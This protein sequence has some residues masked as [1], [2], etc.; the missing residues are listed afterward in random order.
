MKKAS[1]LYLNAI[2][3]LAVLTINALA[4][5]LPINGYN[6]GQVSA[7]Y[8]SL[9]T[10]A[11]FTFSIWSVIYLLLILFAFSQKRIFERD[12]FSALSKWFLI[13]CT[14]NFCWILAWHYLL[15]EVSVL[16]MLL[17][18]I[19]LIK[20]FTLLHQQEFSMV[21]T[22]TFQLPFTFYFSWICVATIANISAVLV[23]WQWLGGPLSPVYWTI[24]LIIIAALLGIFIAG[25]FR[26]PAFLLVTAWAL[27][28][29]HSRWKDGEFKIIST[30]AL[31]SIIAALAFFVFQVI[32]IFRKKKLL[33][34]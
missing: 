8:P 4:N 1:L 5:I 20:I 19:S 30:A 31:A 10:P 34:K 18:L 26:S 25:K 12:F 13:S 14:A 17:L 27:F 7:F 6:T 32:V 21:E 23:H 15:P 22:I 24:L 9:F 11:G 28:G 16:I 33:K 3:L 29:I 2:A